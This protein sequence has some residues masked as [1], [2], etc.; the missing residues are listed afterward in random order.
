[1]VTRCP[2]CAYK[3]PDEPLSLDIIEVLSEPDLPIEDY[4]LWMRRLFHNRTTKTYS[5]VKVH[6]GR[7]HKGEF[8]SPTFEFSKKE[9]EIIESSDVR[10]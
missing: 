2:Y 4:I 1:M 8:N 9:I 10:S 5:G 3:Y 6:I 7:K